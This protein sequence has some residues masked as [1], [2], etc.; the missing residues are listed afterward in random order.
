MLVFYAI[1]SFLPLYG[2]ENHID[3][4]TTGLILGL[5]AVVYVLAQF[6][7]GRLADRYGSRMPIMLG[8]VL[9]TA[10]L[11]MITLIPSAPVWFAAVVLSGIGVSALWVVSNSYL[12]YAAPAAILGT[13]MGL[14]GTFKEIGDGGGPVL[15]GFLADWGGLKAAFLLCIVFTGLSFML[16]FMIKDEKKEALKTEAVAKAKA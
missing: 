4:G 3:T 2:T 1:I 8:S 7:C 16:S 12:A 14:S 15:V 5:Q 9:L 11:L 13:V 6:Y 10:A